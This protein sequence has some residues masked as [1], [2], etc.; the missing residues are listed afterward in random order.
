MRINPRNVL[1]LGRS[2]IQADTCGS[3]DTWSL[4]PVSE[5]CSTHSITH[6][7][8]SFNPICHGNKM[9]A[10]QVEIKITLSLIFYLNAS[11]T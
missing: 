9:Q 7:S 10:K 6:C 5:I 1:L 3:L 11:R 2:E 4:S 8:F